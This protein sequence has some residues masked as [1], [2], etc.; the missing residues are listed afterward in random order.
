MALTQI[1]GEQ[2]RD[3]IVYNRHIAADAAV[4]YSK[5][6]LAGRIVATDLNTDG[7]VAQNV[8]SSK[9]ITL[10]DMVQGVTTGTGSSV[11]VTSLV[12]ASAANDSV[13]KTVAAKGILT[14]GSGTNGAGV[15]NYKVQIRNSSSGEPIADGTGAG[16]N[17]T[18]ANGATVYGELRHDGTAWTLYFFKSDNTAYSFASSAQIDFLFLEIYSLLDA[19]AKGFI[20]GMGFAD[21]V[22]ISGSHNHNDLYYTQT[23]LNGGQLDTRYFT[24]TE[25]TGGSLDGRYYTETE[26]NPAAALAANVLDARYY[27]ES[28]LGSVASGSSGADKIGITAGGGLAAGTVQ[29]ALA[30]LQGDIN[31]IIGG[32][33]DIKFSMDDTYNDGSVVTVDNTNVDFKVTDTKSFQVS[34]SAGVEIVKVDALLAGDKVKVNA[35][36]TIVGDLLQSGGAVTL[37]AG[38]EAVN[39][40][41]GAVTVDGSSVAL[42]STGALTLKDSFL[43][44]GI[45]ISQ[46]DNAALVGYTATSIV[47]ALNEAKAAA[48]TALGIGAAEDA[49]YTDGLFV[50]FVPATPVGTAVDRFNEVLKS[51]APQPAPVLGNIGTDVDGVTGRLSFGASNTIAGY[52]NHPTLDIGGLY[53]KAGDTMGIFPK[54]GTIT[55][56]LAN[57]TPV[58]GANDRPYPAKAFGN[59]ELGTLKLVVNGVEVHST[60][61]TTFASGNSVNANGSGFSLSA[62]A[63][64]KF[65]NGNSFEVFKYRTGS[66]IVGVADFRNGYN[67]VQVIHTTTGDSST[68]TVNFVID[69]S[70]TATS[71]S[72]ETLSSTAMT[73]SNVISGVTYNTAGTVSYAVTASNV[74]KNTYNSGA[75]AVNYTGVNASITDEIITIPSD[76]ANSLVLSKSATISTGSRL[77]NGNVTMN[78][79]VARTLQ[80]TSTSSGATLGGILLDATVDNSTATLES[81][82]GEKFRMNNTVSTTVTAGY[83]DTGSSPNEWS[84]NQSLVGADAAHNDGLLVYNG[85]LVYPTSGLNGGVFTTSNGPA[86]PDYSGATGLRTYYRYFYTSSAKSNFRLAM[87]SASTAFVPVATG[88]SGNNLTMQ[89]LAP[90]TTG[91]WKDGAV[92]YTDDAAVGCYAATYGGSIPSNWGMTLGTKNTST[93][94]NVIVIKITA[95]AA[96]TG[97]ISDITITW[98]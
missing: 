84:S 68:N 96:W 60:D 39:V 34:D 32:A 88:A 82:N 75:T 24:E 67:T 77:L 4:A 38:T 48:S 6:D 27:T 97:N 73:G 98:L 49:S 9:L 64:V 26:L 79:N 51:L 46:T 89:V 78:V 50:D 10:W 81:F 8:L 3:G 28:E 52:T 14:T 25:L 19:P 69:D 74:Y 71:Y 76:E 87:T 40:D 83:S 23:E 2:I 93:S 91:G 12:E 35:D 13:Q 5:L 43:T 31:D 7:S 72:A 58:G 94:G 42:A 80:T 21:V 95:A 59:G 55:G 17:E 61:L 44:A 53:T 54:S 47:G 70:T 37:N 20:A 92:S 57:S 86:N 22:G 45:P 33:V 36:T 29:G 1:R 90:N 62:A 85:Q 56:L 30:E 15:Q 16:D 66:Y 18:A 11:V 41:G 65:D 63:A